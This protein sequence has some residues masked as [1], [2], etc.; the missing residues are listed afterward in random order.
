[1]SNQRVERLAEQLG[2]PGGLLD[3]PGALQRVLIDLQR[4]LGQGSPVPSEKV[5]AIIDRHGA[6]RD[7]S[8]ALLRNLTE[9]DESN[10]VVGVM[11]LSLNDHRHKFEV[12]GKNMS[13]WCAEDTLFLPLVLGRTARVESASPVTQMPIRIIVGPDGVQEASPSTA[14]VSIP[15]VNAL[16]ANV[17]TV[18]KIWTTF[19]HHMHFFASREEAQEWATDRDNIEILSLDEGYALGKLIVAGLLAADSEVAV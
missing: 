17:D 6:D 14:V 3:Y 5:E 9:R 4:T 11:G 2:G 13:A 18:Q 7:A 8:H 19:C 15:V 1:M 10:A 16:E 12:D